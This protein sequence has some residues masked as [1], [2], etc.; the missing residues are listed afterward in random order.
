MTC[1]DG[2]T[3]RTSRRELVKIGRELLYGNVPAKEAYRAGREQ[4]LVAWL[5]MR[6]T[7]A[8]RV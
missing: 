6:F 3:M 2:K 8:E 4:V 1:D 7:D 5:A